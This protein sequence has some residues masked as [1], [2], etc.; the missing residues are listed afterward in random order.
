MDAIDIAYVN[1]LIPEGSIIVGLVTA[2]SYVPPD[3]EGEMRWKVHTDMD[4][5]L[6]TTLGLLELAKL[7]LIASSNTGLPLNYPEDGDG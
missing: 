7:H 3:G 6:T 2:L 5:P 4:A 1:S